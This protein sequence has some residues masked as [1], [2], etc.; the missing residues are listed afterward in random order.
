MSATQP[1]VCAA[2]LLTKS[3]A[4]SLYVEPYPNCGFEKC[5]LTRLYEAKVSCWLGISHP[6]Q[7]PSENNRC[8]W[9]E[10][11]GF[12]RWHYKIAIAECNSDLQC[13]KAN[14]DANVHVCEAVHTHSQRRIL[15][16]FLTDTYTHCEEVSHCSF[17]CL[18][19]KGQVE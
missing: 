9:A 18:G 10:L 14:V 13:R 6:Q 5:C 2:I 17:Q 19:V 12:V 7:D 11:V 8:D 15:A 3:A 1:Q 16:L 4:S